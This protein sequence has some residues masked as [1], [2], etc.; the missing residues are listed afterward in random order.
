M[1]G[2]GDLGSRIAHGLVG[3]GAQVYTLTRRDPAVTGTVA[4]LGDVGDVASL[5]KLPDA[6]DLVVYCL[7]PAARDEASY[8]RAY[9]D[10]LGNVIACL[11]AAST[12]RICFVSST[13]VYG[14]AGGDWVDESSDC[15]PPAFNGRVLLQAEAIALQGGNGLVL[16]LGGIYGPGRESLLRSARA[17]TPLPN[18]ALD[19]GN[20]IH[21][22]DAAAAACHLISGRFSGIFNIVDDLPAPTAEVVAYLALRM[23]LP[24]PTSAQ[25]GSRAGGRRVRNAKLHA[26]GF[27]L[28]YPDFRAGYDAVLAERGA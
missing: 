17:Q 16:R 6:L 22:D 25:S 1:V 18:S 26:A 20:R 4:L 2:C 10:G 11:P 28:Q 21:V 15:D 12:V 24:V 7:T 23:Q 14:A 9:V 8:Q 3:P 5:P 13:A 19:W 27:R